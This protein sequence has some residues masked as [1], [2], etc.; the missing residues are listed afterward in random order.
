MNRRERRAAAA[1]NKAT[2][3]SAPVDIADLMAEATQA[4]EQGESARAEVVCAQILARAPAHAAGLSLLGKIYSETGRHRLAVK[5]LSKA[6]TAD[7]FNIVSHYNIA[8]AYQALNRP[9]DATAHFKKAIALGMSSWEVESLVMQKTVVMNCAR[10]ILEKQNLR[11]KNEAIFQDGDVATIADDPLIRCAL[12]SRILSHV[13][14][15]IFL[16]DLRAALLH[17]ARACILDRTEADDDVVGL[18]CALGQQ[19][20][21]NEYIFVHSGEE[22]RLAD[23]LREMLLRQLSAGGDI[24]PLLLAAVAAYFPLYSLPEAKRLLAREWPAGAAE[25]IRQQL[26]EPLEEAED[27]SAILALTAID[28]SVSVDVM[29]QYE[30]NPYPRCTLTPIAAPAAATPL[31]MEAADESRPCREIL[32]AGCGTGDIAIINAQKYPQAR[33]LAVDLSRAS[34]AYARRKTRELGIRN[35]EYAQADILKLASIG[36]TF[37]RIEVTG[38]LHHLADP[39]AGWRALLSQLRPRGVMRVGLYSRT[40]RRAIVEARALIADRGYR[41]TAEDIRA[42]R[43]TILRNWNEPRWH[44]LIKTVDFF[45]V[46]GCRDMLFN[47]ME[48]QLTIPEIAAFLNENKLSFLGFELDPDVIAKFQEQYP[49][50]EGLANLDYWNAFETANPRTFEHMYIF[51]L[52]KDGPAAH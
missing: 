37:D 36:R 23:Q 33:V 5:T 13:A 16:T 50:A 14:L 39:K 31:Q 30:E 27:R 9:A 47:V 1:H 22:T 35:V 26:R 34:L 45:S 48:H 28:D 20:F 6:I 52:G 43:Q 10:R 2:A 21:M 38:V 32:V 25:L 12:E 42:F 24:P 3:R 7:D 40:A 49:G 11:G 44:T 17:I 51:S 41:A 29:H 4:Y 46:S 8:L 15:E 19:C 18:F